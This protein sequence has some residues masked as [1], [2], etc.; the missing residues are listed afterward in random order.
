MIGD[1]KMLFQKI[2]NRKHGVTARVLDHLPKRLQT[3]LA[4]VLS[5]SYQY[6]QLDPYIKCILAIEHKQGKIKLIDTD[7]L[8]A[9]EQ[10]EK[11]MISIQFK[12]TKVERVED[13]RL[14]LQSGVIFARHYHPAPHKKLPMV[15]YYHGGGFIF[16][17]LNSYD[18]VCRLLAI[19]ANVQV[20]SIEYP[21]APEVGPEKIIQICEDALAWTYQNRKN[22]KILKNRI[23]VAGDSAGGN[24]ATVIA[25]K[26]LKKNHAPCAQL[27]IYP[28]TDFKNKY[29]SYYA[30][31]EGL[32]LTGQDVEMMT[33]QYVKKFQI[34]LDHPLVSPMFGQLKNIAPAFIVTVTHDVLHD[35]GEIYAHRL[36]YSGVKIFYKNYI[37]QTHG[38][39]NLTPISN[40]SKKYSIEI[41]KEFRQ[42]WDQ[43]EGFFRGLLFGRFFP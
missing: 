36:Q 3:S 14:P 19:N 24:I 39:I 29:P 21:L 1:N 13:L 43:Q 6:P 37:D 27:L 2:L 4:D 12:P 10:F 7:L 33:E 18:E 23:A 35:E 22:L 41:F 28:K 40:R 9:R 30:Y 20:L 16:G 42:F 15:I 34:E 5:Y 31:K 11:Q 38:F 8:H 17:S 25:Q 32:F 26:S